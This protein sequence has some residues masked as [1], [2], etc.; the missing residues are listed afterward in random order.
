MRLDRI[1]RLEWRRPRSFLQLH[2]VHPELPFGLSRGDQIHRP[3]VEVKSGVEGE[4]VPLPVLADR[5]RFALCI[6]GF[7]PVHRIRPDAELQLRRRCIAAGE[8]R[9]GVGLSA[10][11]GY[12]R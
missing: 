5:Y 9:E 7:A 1:P 2:G 3:L 4:L 8:Y 6:R 12:D 10:L 11:H